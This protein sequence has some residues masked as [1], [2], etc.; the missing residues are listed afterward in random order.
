MRSDI[1]TYELIERYLNNELSADELVDFKKEL[2]TNPELA[3]EVN[4]QQMVQTVT[5]DSHLATIKDKT[6]AYNPYFSP[7]IRVSKYKNIAL[8]LFTLLGSVGLVYTISQIGEKE[9]I[10]HSVISQPIN[11]T[12]SESNITE[13]NSTGIDNSKNPTSSSITEKIIINKT[14]NHVTHSSHNVISSHSN[15]NTPSNQNSISN[16]STPKKT[17]KNDQFLS[18]ERN[19]TKI[20][21]GNEIVKKSSNT[22]ANS[23][24]ERSSEKITTILVTNT[25]ETIRSEDDTINVNQKFMKEMEGIELERPCQNINLKIKVHTTPSCTGNSN[26]R[27]EISKIQGGTAPYSTKIDN[28]EFKNSTTYRN[29]NA[30]MHSLHIKD[31]EGC[32]HKYDVNIKSEN[33]FKVYPINPSQQHFWKYNL[34]PK[35]DYSVAIYSADET[36]VYKIAVKNKNM[37]EWNGKSQQGNNLTEGKYTFIITQNGKEHDKGYIKI[38]K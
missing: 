4:V 11:N 22:S 23:Y 7:S 16:S 29:L 12:T 24:T 19:E 27:I 36:L 21:E 8:A 30:G 32:G 38:K 5:V 17:V 1:E 2:Q 37:L 35:G 14:P 26:G 34:S 3:N 10:S 20:V 6:N 33:C 18:L 9:K 31:S 15:N 25:N 13:N 28:F